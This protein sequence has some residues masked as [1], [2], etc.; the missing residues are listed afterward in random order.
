M[1]CRVCNQDKSPHLFQ[2]AEMERA[3]NG[4][5]ARCRK[6]SLEAQGCEFGKTAKKKQRYVAINK[7]AERKESRFYVRKELKRLEME[8]LL[9]ARR[10]RLE[11]PDGEAA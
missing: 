10:M 6:C 3:S 1:I 9:T 4:K 11:K 5:S 2:P 7:I 8:K